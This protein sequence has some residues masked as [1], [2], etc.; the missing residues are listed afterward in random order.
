[1][2]VDAPVVTTTML[3]PPQL[4]RWTRLPV[5]APATASVGTAPR[6]MSNSLPRASMRVLSD[7]GWSGSASCQLDERREGG[8]VVLRGDR[9]LEPRTAVDPLDDPVGGLVVLE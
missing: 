2:S 8:A 4:R 6:L 1:M 9:G 5:T 3:T 7:V